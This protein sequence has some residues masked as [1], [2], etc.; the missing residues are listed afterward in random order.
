MGVAVGLGTE[1]GIGVG[2]TSLQ[3]PS[4]INA[5]KPAPMITNPRNERTFCRIIHP[6]YRRASAAET[7]RRALLKV[8]YTPCLW[9]RTQF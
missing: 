8:N 2:E 7:L 5:A 6:S 9:C 3:A 4:T 1:V